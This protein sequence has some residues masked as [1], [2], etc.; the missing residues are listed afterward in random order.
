LSRLKLVTGEESN[1]GASVG[2]CFD[3]SY[4]GQEYKLKLFVENGGAL[5]LLGYVSVV[6]VPIP[7]GMAT[8]IDS[9]GGSRPKKE[10]VVIAERVKFRWFDK[11]NKKKVVIKKALGLKNKLIRKM[12]IEEEDVRIAGQFTQHLLEYTPPERYTSS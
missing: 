8:L 11:R 12:Q 9:V 5:V 6:E 4:K 3:F 1:E 7:E 10:L 2:G